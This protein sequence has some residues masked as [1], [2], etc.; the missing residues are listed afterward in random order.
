M[1]PDSHPATDSTTDVYMVFCGGIDQA[2]L[3]RIFGNLSLATNPAKQVRAVHL[4]FQST[5]GNVGDGVCL[6]NFFRA[7]PIDLVIYNVG[8]VW[9]AAALAYL[10]AVKRKTS[11]RASFMLHRTHVS[12]KFAKASTLKAIANSI[13]LDDS[14]IESILR[15]HITL[16][17][18]SAIDQQDVFFS[19]EEA[20]KIGLANEIGE[21]APPPR[22]QL[23]NI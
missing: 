15:D 17:D 11:A 5:G 10:G 9:S 19:G 20:I 3:Q 6:Y 7:F 13:A 14:R 16:E 2:A 23:F 22:T 21:F 18:W 1:S 8:T 12:P 4:L